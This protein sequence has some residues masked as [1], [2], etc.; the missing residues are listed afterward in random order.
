MKFGMEVFEGVIAKLLAII[1]ND[2]VR[3]PE[4]ADD[5]PPEETLDLAFSDMC[6]WFRFHPLREVVNYNDE[7]LHLARY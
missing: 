1:G 3:N 2:C 4:S 7:K 6:Q 5:R